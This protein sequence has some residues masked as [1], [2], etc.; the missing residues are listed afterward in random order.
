LKSDPPFD[1]LSGLSKERMIEY[2]EDHNKVHSNDI[3]R[4]ILLY[5]KE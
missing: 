3:L 4:I 1:G 5:P 2:I